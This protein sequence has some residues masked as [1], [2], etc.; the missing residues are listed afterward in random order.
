MIEHMNRATRRGY[1]GGGG[2]KEAGWTGEPYDQK[3]AE[4]DQSKTDRQIMI[5]KQRDR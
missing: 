4:T 1:E 3:K 5:S 2:C